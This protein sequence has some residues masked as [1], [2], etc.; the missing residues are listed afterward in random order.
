MTDRKVTKR[1]NEKVAD[2]KS[3]AK[4][5]DEKKVVTK[6]SGKSGTAKTTKKA[7]AKKASPNK[8]AS[9]KTDSKK[10]EKQGEAKDKHGKKY[11]KAAPLIEKGK[12]YE[13]SEAVDL[14]KKTTVTKFDSSVEI[15]MNLN[16]DPKEAD[17]QVRGTVSLPAGSGKVKTVCVITVIDKEKEAKE[18]GADYVGSK[19]LIEKISKGWTDFDVCVASPEVMGDLGKIGKVLGTKGLMPSP[20]AGTVTAEVGKAVKDIKKGRAD[21]KADPAGIIHSSVGKVSFDSKDL[22][23]NIETFVSAIKSAKPSGVKGAFIESIY[24]TTTMGPS[25][26]LENK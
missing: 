1:A 12:E 18:A 25:I 10:P 3:E 15:H 26:R 6:V 5:A 22:S 13:L 7:V 20:K 23:E 9:K 14:I 24:L 8:E 11:K 17:Q 19:D 2:K 4:K 21:Y 16:I